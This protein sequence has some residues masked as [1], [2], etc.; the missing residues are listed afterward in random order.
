MNKYVEI[1]ILICKNYNNFEI[2]IINL[3]I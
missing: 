2:K 3:I 1:L